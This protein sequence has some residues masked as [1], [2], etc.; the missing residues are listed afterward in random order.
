[1]KDSNDREI[2]IGDRVKLRN[3]VYPARGVMDWMVHHTNYASRPAEVV[4]FA[5]TRVKVKFIGCGGTRTHP[6]DDR[7]ENVAPEY[8]IVIGDD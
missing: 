5:R 3:V 4:G 7:T 1:M 2:Q 6:E 8:L